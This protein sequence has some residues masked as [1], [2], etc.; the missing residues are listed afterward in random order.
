MQ[1]G[2]VVGLFSHG[3]TSPLNYR[4]REN[5]ATFQYTVENNRSGIRIG[6]TVMF[7]D[8]SFPYEFSLQ[9]FFDTGIISVE[10]I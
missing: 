4:I 6:D 1:G 9:V 10:A 7:N 5:F 3:G 8:V 2:D